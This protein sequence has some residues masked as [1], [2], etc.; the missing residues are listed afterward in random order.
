VALSFYLDTNLI[1]G[2]FTS[3][4]LSERAEVFLTA[5][6]GPFDLSDLAAAEFSAVIARQV[7]NRERPRDEA[8]AIFAEFDSWCEASAIR[9]ALMSEHLV[10]ADRYLRRLDLALLAP[11]AIHI[12]IA[13]LNGS[14]VVTFD[15]QMAAA[16][17]VLGIAVVEP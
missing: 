9:I 14:T 2:F 10:V 1:V 17:R 8:M 7:R 6:R 4:S 16:A 11:D 15:R 13:H 5:N 12:A 3:D